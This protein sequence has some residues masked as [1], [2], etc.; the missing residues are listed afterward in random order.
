[1]IGSDK[2]TKIYVRR[3]GTFMNSK[4]H[5]EVRHRLSAVMRATKHNDPR[6]STLNLLF[7][8]VKFATEKHRGTYSSSPRQRH[9]PDS[10][11]ATSTS[12]HAT[13]VIADENAK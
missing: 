1:M 4:T 12:L 2:Y 3:C 13:P 10:N 8:S 9:A 11:V 7:V 6:C 5:G